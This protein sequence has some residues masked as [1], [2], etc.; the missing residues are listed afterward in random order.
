MPVLKTGLAVCFGAMEGVTRN[1][2]FLFTCVGGERSSVGADGC[3]VEYVLPRYFVGMYDGG[4][5]WCVPLSVCGV[6]TL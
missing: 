1:C 3:Y 5:V 4:V 2:H 6:Q